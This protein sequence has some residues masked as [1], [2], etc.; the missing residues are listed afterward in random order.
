VYSTLIQAARA[1][2]RWKPQ[3]EFNHA[4]NGFAVNEFVVEGD[5]PDT[6]KESD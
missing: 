5:S 2:E 1:S 4:N 6:V 3:D